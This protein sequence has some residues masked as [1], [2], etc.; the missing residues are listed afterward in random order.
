M[1]NL[2]TAIQIVGILAGFFL[3]IGILP[4]IY[5]IIK[6]KQTEGLSLISY[7]LLAI[8]Q[9]LWCTYGVLKNDLRIILI[10]SISFGL[11][12][13]IMLL[14]I[15]FNRKKVSREMHTTNNINI[16]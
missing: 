5:K 4:Q 12:I 3:I 8:S 11:T 6:T 9:G 1:D 10:N 13:I 2:D 16:T 14:V 7:T 15:Y